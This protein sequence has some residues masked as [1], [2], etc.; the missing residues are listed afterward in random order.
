[1][2][3]SRPGTCGRSL[4]R[5]ESRAYDAPVLVAL[6]CAIATTFAYGVSTVLQAVGARRVAD[7]GGGVD[8]SLLV[9][10]AS[11]APFL[12][13][14]ALDVAAVGFTIVALR[15]LDLFVVQAA[16]A[17]SL[18]VTALVAAK[19]FRARLGRN[20]WLAIG[21]VA[22][23]LVML[24]LSAG[25]EAPPSTSSSS[26]LILVAAIVVVALLSIPA[27]RLSKIRAATALGAL[28]GIAYGTA[29]TALR[30]IPDF[31]PRQ[32]VTNVVAYVAIAG[33][34]LGI[35]LFATGLQ[36]GS[37]TVATGAMVVAETILPSLYGAVVLGERPRNG[38]M[39][40]AVIGFIT[41]IGAAVTL[42][43]F[44]EGSA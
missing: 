6:V 35:L 34:I 4:G 33:A 36:R 20:E 19:V 38:W 9:R 3:A 22:V 10:L 32:L 31:S 30:V 41:T 29:N 17:A 7:A 15:R 39:A 26:R 11:Q 13:G 43:R 8:P 18:A 25:P 24:A 44:G 23:G 12:A 14:L 28:S 5:D 42:S 1:M 21:A 37:V 27:G 2:P 16:I 40:V